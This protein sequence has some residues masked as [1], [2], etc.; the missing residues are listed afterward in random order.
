LFTRAFVRAA[1]A[2]LALN[3]ANFLFIHF[4]GFL[5]RLGADEAEIGR[6]MAAQP[7]GAILAWPFAGR[8]TDVY[9]RR[10][11]ILAGCATFIV[12]IVLYLQ[13]S[14]LGPFIYLVRLLDGMAATM[15]YAALITHAAD[16]VPAHRRTEGLAIF[17]ASGLATIGL[18][19]LFGDWILAH[20]GYRGLFLGALV[21]TTLG[22]FLCWRLRDVG[23]GAGPGARPSR[24]I[25]AAAKQ[26]NLRPIWYAAFAFFV[27]MGTLFFFVKTFIS[28]VGIGS[29]GGFF[30]AYA[31]IAIT[32]RFLVGWLP[33]RIGSRRMLGIAMLSYALGFVVLAF[34]RT[35]TYILV[36]GLLCGA[37]HGYTYPVLFSL[38]VER[39]ALHERGAAMAFYTAVDW[40]GLLVAGPAIGYTID[41]AGYRG[42]FMGIVLALIVG[43]GLFYRLDR[44]AAPTFGTEQ[45]GT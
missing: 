21:C 2:M 5:Q 13:I 20:A 45:G 30:A 3:L 39:A 36:A 11:V 32:L 1:A 12:A 19:A 27:A 16:L 38:A 15:W 24:G 4:P 8:A 37:G 25:F 42:A 26:P 40:L 22:L 35:P 41:V 31:V 34:A 6:I 23:I 44:F 18:G 9:G 43:I 7:L 28:A 29:V 10:I 33:D 17:G 14:S